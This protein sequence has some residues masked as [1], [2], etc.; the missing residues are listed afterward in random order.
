M[1]KNNE[2]LWERIL[3]KDEDEDE[4]DRHVSSIYHFHWPQGL[5]PSSSV[6]Y[7]NQWTPFWLGQTQIFEYSMSNRGFVKLYVSIGLLSQIRNSSSNIRTFD[8]LVNMSQ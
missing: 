7:I 5:Q 4:G 2:I 8:K 6:Q 3:A 1:I